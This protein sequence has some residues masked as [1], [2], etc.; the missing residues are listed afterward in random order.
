MERVIRFGKRGKLNPRY[1][2]P[3]KIL[4]KV[5]ALAY[6][7]ELPEQ[8]SQVYSTFHVSKLK[9]CYVDEPLAIPLDE[10]QID[11]KLNFIEESVEIMDREVKR[12]KQSRIPIVKVRCNSRRGPEFT[13]EREDQMKKKYLHLFVLSYGCLCLLYGVA[14]HWTDFQELLLSMLTSLLLVVVDPRSGTNNRNNNWTGSNNQPRKLNRPN[15]VYTHC[16]MN[17][18]DRC[19]ELVGYPLNFKKNTGANRGSA[20]NNVVTRNRDQSN[21]F[22]DDQ[23]KRLMYLISEKS[24]S[25][26]IP[27]NIAG[28]NCVTLVQVSI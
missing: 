28:T 12:L 1:I 27:A 25:S 24:G 18:A 23:Y 4:A 7:L 26:S 2:G 20:S 6:R 16:N 17:S 22:T 8:L 14:L 13:W 3:F 15:L 19:T 10:I 11:D 21:T 5:G 9:K